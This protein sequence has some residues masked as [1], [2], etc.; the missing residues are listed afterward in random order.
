MG[1]HHVDFPVTVLLGGECDLCA[2]W[3]PSGPCVG[4]IVC[5][6]RF[7]SNHLHEI[8]V[9]DTDI[10]QRV[11]FFQIKFLLQRFIAGIGDGMEFKLL[12][13][14]AE[15]EALN[16]YPSGCVKHLG[17]VKFMEKLCKRQ[18]AATLAEVAGWLDIHAQD[19]ASSFKEML[20]EK[21]MAVV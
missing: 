16:K 6:E 9:T 4:G 17:L 21:G 3:R 20:A 13:D 19:I 1:I 14:K 5:C 12:A 11:G 18:Q 8:K 7:E 2:V 15:I 10:S